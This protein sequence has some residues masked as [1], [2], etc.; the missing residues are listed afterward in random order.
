MTNRIVSQ[1]AILIDLKKYRI[2]IYKH[3]IHSLGDPEYILLLVY[4]QS[5]SISIERSS[6]LDKRA[7]HLVRSPSDNH[8]SPEFF[9]RQL[10]RT[11]FNLCGQWQKDCS[12]RIYGKTTPSDRVA[13]FNI[14]DS[15]LFVNNEV[16]DYGI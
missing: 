15:I 13:R 11:L 3:T 5:R 8:R 7:H 16:K 12:Y 2:R 9:S 14:A 10:I 1:P 6:R 4:P